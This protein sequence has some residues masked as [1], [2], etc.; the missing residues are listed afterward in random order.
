VTAN[1]NNKLHM[2]GMNNQPQLIPNCEKT[3]VHQSEEVNTLYN[4]CQSG[5]KNR[6]RNVIGW[7]ENDIT[8]RVK[9]S[10][11]NAVGWTR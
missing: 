5:M 4:T 6:E 10:D 1:A 2:K 9:R 7:E 8:V 11:T 3:I